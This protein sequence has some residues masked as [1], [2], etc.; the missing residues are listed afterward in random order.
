MRGCGNYVACVILCGCVL[1]GEEILLAGKG[2]GVWC[3]YQKRSHKQAWSVWMWMCSQCDFMCEWVLSEFYDNTEVND[4][5]CICPL[6]A[7]HIENEKNTHVSSY[8][9]GKGSTSHIN[10]NYIYVGSHSGGSIDYCMKKMR[11]NLT[12]CQMS[13]SGRPSGGSFACYSFICSYLQNVRYLTC[14]YYQT[15]DVRFAWL[16]LLPHVLTSSWRCR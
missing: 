10:N 12:K 1:N 2:M 7:L 16:F 6:E 13:V 8:S 9:D 14:P 4:I 15:F 11:L 5:L 3:Q